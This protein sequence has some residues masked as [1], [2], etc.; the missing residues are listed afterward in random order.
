[1]PP[2]ARRA[3]PARIPALRTC[4][5]NVV[6]SAAAQTHVSGSDQTSPARGAPAVP[7]RQR[8]V[9]G[10]VMPG[11]PPHRTSGIPG[12]SGRAGSSFAREAPPIAS[13]IPAASKQSRPAPTKAGW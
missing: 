1:M 12:S 3:S 11:D 7:P 8:I 5:P 6:S 10:W 9:Q 4:P 13:T 2:A